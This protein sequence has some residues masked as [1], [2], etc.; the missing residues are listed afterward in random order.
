M[1]GI[2]SGLKAFVFTSEHVRFWKFFVEHPATAVP[3]AYPSWNK[4][5]D[6]GAD[7]WHRA[8]A[9]PL[10]QTESPLRSLAARQDA[11]GTCT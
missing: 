1:V 3:A 8:T 2:S 9:K 11:L 6:T 10:K 7:P 5:G 4:T